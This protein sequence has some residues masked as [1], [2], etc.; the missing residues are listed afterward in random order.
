M[1]LIFEFLFTHNNVRH[2]RVVKFLQNAS[3]AATT[4]A[5]GFG[6]ALDVGRGMV[7]AGAVLGSGSDAVTALDPASE[8]TLVWG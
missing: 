6:M 5:D 8:W 2:T 1:G 4:E 3:D 7:N